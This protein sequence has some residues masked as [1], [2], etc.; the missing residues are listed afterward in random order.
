MIDRHK[1]L[2]RSLLP[3]AAMGALICAPAPAAHGTDCGSLLSLFQEGR[4][5]VEIARMTGL[6]STEVGDCR[7]ELSRPIFVGPEG[8][9]PYGAAGPPP[10]NAAGP[11]PGG[12]A[13]PPPVGPAGPPPKGREVKR[14]P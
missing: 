8:V 9:P 7:R 5:T 2:H 14:L 12:A 13:G 11:P 6:T 4:S 3:A 1:W 10:R